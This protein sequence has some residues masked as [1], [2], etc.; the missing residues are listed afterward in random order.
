MTW[1][2]T[3]FRGMILLSAFFFWFYT[4]ARGECTPP[5]RTTS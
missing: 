5:L 3:T 1:G 4:A 2:T